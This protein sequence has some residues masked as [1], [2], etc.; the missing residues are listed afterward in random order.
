VGLV[1]RRRV[2]LGRRGGLRSWLNLSSR[3]VSASAAVGPVT[4]NS[5]GRITIRLGRYLSLRL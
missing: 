4:V 1:F 3:G 5:R 2:S